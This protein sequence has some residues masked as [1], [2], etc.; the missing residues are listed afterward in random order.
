MDKIA[1]IQKHVV[2]KAKTSRS[3]NEAIQFWKITEKCIHLIPG[4][5]TS[6]IS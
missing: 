4:Q 6:T 1:T 3:N 2:E 5:Y